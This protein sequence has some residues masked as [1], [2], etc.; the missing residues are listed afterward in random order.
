MSRGVGGRRSAPTQQPLAAP[1]QPYQQADQPHA[2]AEVEEVGGLASGV[3]ASNK[4]SIPSIQQMHAQAAMTA[5]LGLVHSKYYSDTM[6]DSI[7][8]F[9]YNPAGEVTSAPPIPGS[10]APPIIFHWD[11]PTEDLG[12][13]L[14]KYLLSY[15]GVL[16]VCGLTAG[17]FPT[18]YV[19]P[20]C[21]ATF[22]G[23]M[24]LPVFHLIPWQDEDAD[25]AVWLLILSL[26]FGPAV[27]LV[28]YTVICLLRQEANVSV[29]ALLGVALF[30]RGVMELSAGHGFSMMILNPP[31]ITP[32]PATNPEDSISLPANIF[33]SW[34]SLLAMAG[35]Y[36]A[37]VFHK[38]DE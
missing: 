30:S 17:F 38:A 37:N 36:I 27:G 19:A 16:L 33:T 4:P 15:A 12:P 8:G 11:E 2:E 24:F 6:V 22:F 10:T 32:P 18:A 3:A 20:L 1:T 14:L 35:W 7:S 5:S 31:W 9:H 26:V 21:F 34:T 13:L 28:I 25:D 23:G 29:L